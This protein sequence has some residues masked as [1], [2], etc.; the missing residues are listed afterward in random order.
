MTELADPPLHAPSPAAESRD[1]A[2]A[3]RLTGPRFLAD[4]YEDASRC[5]KCSLC[6]AVCPTY[7]VNPVE[8]ETARGR[9]ALVRDA[10]EGNL[11]LRDIA[12]GPLST[13]LACNNCMAACAPAVPTAEIVTRARQE[14]Q[15]QEGHPLGQ[16]VALRGILPH[17]L[18]LRMVHTAGRAA[19]V[20]GLLRLAQRGGITRWMG[21]P[22]AF[23][24]HLGRLPRR[25]AY[26]RA[27]SLAGPRPPVRGRLGFAMCCY[28]NLTAPEAT[29]AT[30]RVLAANGY[31]IVVPTLGCTGL[32]AKSLGDRDAMLEMARKTIE[33]LRE[34]RVDA[35]VGDVA[36]CTMHVREYGRLL[37]DD[38]FVGVDARRLAGSL[39]LASTL[40]ADEGMLAPLGRLRWRVA[41]DEP[42]A[43]P[44]GGAERSA[45]HALLSHVPGLRLMPLE[46]AA[47]CCAGA[48]AYFHSQPERSA[49]ILARKFEHVVASGAEI[50]V[51]ENISC[52]N[53]L[54]DGARRH[55]PHV[56]VMHV[57]EVLQAS[58]EAEQRRLAARER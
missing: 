52:L 34:L 55:A 51:T 47:M 40:L 13:C 50:L 54:R 39:R 45:P 31:E 43:L 36:S 25:T 24:E 33:V 49:A 5:N 8:W 35:F 37:G 28:Q 38:R 32:P 16:T 17:P 12:D 15:A 4:I 44:H 53:Q 2:A 3:A 7:V 48:G 30:L 6:Q 1:G 42:C 22:G 26:K 46:E 14:L 58:I 29:E 10:I 27:K 23:A 21:L 19:Q 18:M 11:D 20:T 57:F 41:I 9:V 56:R